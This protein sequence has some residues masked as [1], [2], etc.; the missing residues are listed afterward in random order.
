MRIKEAE[1][2]GIKI[3]YLNKFN[4][5]CILHGKLTFVSKDSVIVMD[6]F[7]KEHPIK[8]DRIKVFEVMKYGKQNK[9]KTI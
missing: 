7:K 9:S 5:Q 8:R 4:Y 1:N 3:T 2:K 6:C